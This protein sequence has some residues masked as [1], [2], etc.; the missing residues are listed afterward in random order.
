MP[1]AEPRPATALGGRRRTRAVILSS[2]C[3]RR[4]GRLGELGLPVHRLS[5]FLRQTLE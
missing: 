1:G 2:A 4:G 3:G 5:F